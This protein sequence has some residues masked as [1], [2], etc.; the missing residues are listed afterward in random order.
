M[1]MPEMPQPA[2]GSQV[3]QDPLQAAQLGVSQPSPQ[4][5]SRI[6]PNV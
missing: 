4:N 5:I 6:L 1:A 3:A 2:A